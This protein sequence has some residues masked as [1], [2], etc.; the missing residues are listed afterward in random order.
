MKLT[1]SATF[2][3]AYL[4]FQIVYPALAW[5]RPGQYLFSWR[6]FAGDID[7]PRYE[8]VFEDGR[9]QPVGDPMER[10]GI[11]RVL[12]QSMEQVPFV[13][14]ALCD[15]MRGAAEARAVFRRSGRVEALRCRSPRP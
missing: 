13:L 6:M 7:R 8:V 2:F 4:A 5:L 1:L 9:R 12:S 15:R 14:P 3:F 11:V 10:G